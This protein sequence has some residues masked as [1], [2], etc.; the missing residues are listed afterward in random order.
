MMS[1]VRNGRVRR[2]MPPCAG[3]NLKWCDGI[4]Y[5]TREEQVPWQ[6]RDWCLQPMENVPVRC[7]V[8]G[9]G[10]KVSVVWEKGDLDFFPGCRRIPVIC[11]DSLLRGMQRHPTA[12][13]IAWGGATAGELAG[14][15]VDVIVPKLLEWTPLASLWIIFVGGGNNVCM[16]KVRVGV[17]EKIVN[18]IVTPIRKLE[19]FCETG[20]HM[21]SVANLIPRP[22]EMCDQS[23]NTLQERMTMV[24]AYVTINEWIEDQNEQ[25]GAPSLQLNKFF[26]YERE[27][28]GGARKCRQRKEAGI[29]IKK[30]RI[31][32]FLKDG[33]HLSPKGMELV[34]G[35]IL[36][37]LEDVM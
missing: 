23:V 8:K 6:P 20:G 32:R 4:S 25:R 35:E 30:I 14:F 7:L 11:S 34:E 2:F 36:K 13:H 22:K 5:S 29:G 17:K 18:D 37:K 27:L 26:H 9:H 3:R 19:G 15:L 16:G 33:V 21:L 10:E 31:G 1:Q 28:K 24:A 12:I